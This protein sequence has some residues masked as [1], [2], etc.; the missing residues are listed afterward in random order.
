MALPTKQNQHEVELQFQLKHLMWNCGILPVHAS[1]SQVNVRILKKQPRK[2][3]LLDRMNQ[4]RGVYDLQTHTYSSEQSSSVVHFVITS[5]SDKSLSNINTSGGRGEEREF[6]RSTLKSCRLASGSHTSFSTLPP[7]TNKVLTMP[8]STQ[9]KIKEKPTPLK[10]R[11][12]S[13]FFILCFLPSIIYLFS[14][15]LKF[16]INWLW[17][18]WLTFL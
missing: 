3:V 14:L 15:W 6:V 17:N 10:Q 13:V 9:A 8:I 12:R 7:T 4:E 1:Q 18:C 16:S 5:S 11:G 2:E